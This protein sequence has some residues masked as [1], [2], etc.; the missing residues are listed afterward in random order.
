MSSKVPVKAKTDVVAMSRKVK[1]YVMDICLDGPVSSSISY[2]Y[3]VIFF[4]C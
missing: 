2:G 4:I 1:A 3:L